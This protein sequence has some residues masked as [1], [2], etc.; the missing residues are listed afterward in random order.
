L[1]AEGMFLIEVLG[2]EA[3]TTVVRPRQPKE[4]IRL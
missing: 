4:A 1:S 3:K 2:L